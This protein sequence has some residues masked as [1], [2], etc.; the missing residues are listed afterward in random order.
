M[1]E[2]KNYVL[3]NSGRTADDYNVVFKDSEGEEVGRLVIEP[4]KPIKFEGEVEESAEIFFN[5]LKERLE[6]FLL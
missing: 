1:S 4:N 5:H 2:E 6:E 3:D